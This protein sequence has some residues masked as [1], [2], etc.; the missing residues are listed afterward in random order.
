MAVGN[1]KG[2]KVK[3]GNETGVAK[4]ATDAILD[5]AVTMA[6]L[7]QELQNAISGGGGGGTG[8]N[9]TTF[10]PSVSNAGVISWT[11]DGNKTNPASV[12]LVAAV[13]SALPSASGRSF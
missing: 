11:N 12:D 3:K 10:Y 4:I 5:K 13:I 1:V 8:A 6:K 2:F 9:G 7:S